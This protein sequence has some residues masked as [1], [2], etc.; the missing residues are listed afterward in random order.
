MAEKR[1]MKDEFDAIRDAQ[2]LREMSDDPM[3]AKRAL[4]KASQTATALRNIKAGKIEAPMSDDMGPSPKVRPV[5]MPEL[6]TKDTGDKNEFDVKG[7]KMPGYENSK[8]MK[9][10]GSVSS[11]SKRADGCAIRGKTRA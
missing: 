3:V 5:K 1:K 8:P 2:A 6:K 9:K 10:G 7:E 4:D 11:A